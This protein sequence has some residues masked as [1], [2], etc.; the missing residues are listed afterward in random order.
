M[1]ILQDPKHQARH[2]EGSQ[3]QQHPTETNEHAK[4]LPTRVQGLEQLDGTKLA[5]G[6]VPIYWG[7]GLRHAANPNPNLLNVL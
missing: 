4:V 5:P 7:R 2:A 6:N 3:C 1:E